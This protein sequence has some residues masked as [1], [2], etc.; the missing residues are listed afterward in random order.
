[1][2]DASEPTTEPPRA[3]AG[4]AVGAVLLLAASMVSPW[5]VVKHRGADGTLLDST[6]VPLFRTADPPDL[7]R[8]WAPLGTGLLAAAALAILATHVA[9]RE[10]RYNPSR[11]RTALTASLALGGLAVLSTLMWP[12]VVPHFWGSD[13]YEVGAGAAGR[14]TEAAMPGWG[15]WAA[16]GAC[17]LLALARW[18]SARPAQPK[19][20]E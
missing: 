8:P 14:F 17:A 15:W 4:Y 5:Y 18:K 16:A 3:G 12:N 2:A 6:G 9:G 7:T 20:V 11:W 13:T 1:M 10:W 19:L